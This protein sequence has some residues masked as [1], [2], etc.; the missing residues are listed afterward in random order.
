MVYFLKQI[1]ERFRNFDRNA[2]EDPS[3]I[4]LEYPDFEPND[5]TYRFGRLVLSF[6]IY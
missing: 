6:F 2:D 3:I 1:M 5:D 4:S